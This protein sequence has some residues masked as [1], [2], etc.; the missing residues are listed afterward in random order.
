MGFYSITP[1]FHLTWKNHSRYN[2]SMFAKVA[3]KGMKIIPNKTIC[4]AE[5]E[6]FNYPLGSVSEKEL[7]EK[8]IHA[9]QDI[10]VFEVENDAKKLVDLFGS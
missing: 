4:L 9:I 6:Y 5:I 3:K 2:E 1:S 10:E 7:L 8:S